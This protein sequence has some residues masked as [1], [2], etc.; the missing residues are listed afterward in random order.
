LFD[1]LFLSLVSYVWF[2]VAGD[3]FFPYF[4]SMM[5]RENRKRRRL[6]RRPSVFGD[7]LF[8]SLFVMAF[9]VC[10]VCPFDLAFFGC[11]VF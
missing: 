4:S 10:K 3:D 5:S 11:S 6:E 1:F 9:A 7:S 2:A 8:L